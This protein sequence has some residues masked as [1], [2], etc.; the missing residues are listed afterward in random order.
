MP[1]FCHPATDWS[2]SPGSDESG[3]L[4]SLDPV[5]REIA[6]W[7]AW[8]TLYRL[9]AGRIA[10]C[11]VTV[12]PCRKGC[13]R[14]TYYVAPVFAG[15]HGGLIS[16]RIVDGQWINSPCGCGGDGCSCTTVHEVILPGVIG[17]VD[18]VKLDGV[19]LD[20]DTYRV[21]NGN[22][23]VRTDGEDWPLCQSMDLPDT[24]EGTFSVTY[25]NGFSNIAIDQ[26]AGR[27]AYELYQACTGG[28][29]SLPMNVTAITRQG[30]T[31]EL[32]A[33]PFTAG[34]TGIY[35]V[36]MVIGIYNPYGLKAPP[37]V[38][39]PESRRARITTIGA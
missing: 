4:E 29:C 28:Q 32:D 27:L 7:N 23:L 30:T 5:K 16:P 34:R 35:E 15:G 11:P 33:S 37:R 22:R 1:T 38:V 9:S 31:F 39:T 19:I 36:D 10:L 21:D 6:E 12:R 24:E 17:R 3:W 20:P 2:C 13:E 14:G 8:A 25:L 26:A 18:E